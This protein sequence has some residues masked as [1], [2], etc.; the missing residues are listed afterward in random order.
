MLAGTKGSLTPDRLRE[1]SSR[2][3]RPPLFISTVLNALKELNQHPNTE[4][5]FELSQVADLLS[6]HN[7][8]QSLE[9]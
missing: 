8:H 1:F 6:T 3:P 2:F 9:Y 4:L 5:S 7:D